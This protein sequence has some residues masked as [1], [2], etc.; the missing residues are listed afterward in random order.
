M[1]HPHLHLNLWPYNKINIS[2]CALVVT[3]PLAHKYPSASY[4]RQA[5]AYGMDSFPQAGLVQPDYSQTQGYSQQNFYR[6]FGFPTLTFVMFYILCFWITMEVNIC[7]KSDKYFQTWS[8]GG[9][10]R[11]Y[12]LQILK[13]DWPIFIHHMTTWQLELCMLCHFFTIS[14]KFVQKELTWFIRFNLVCT[15][16]AGL[17]LMKILSLSTELVQIT[18]S[19]QHRRRE[20]TTQQHQSRCTTLHPHQVDHMLDHLFLPKLS[21]DHHH[22]RTKTRGQ[23]VHGT[24]LLLLGNPKNQNL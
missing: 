11:C 12:S 5:A 24:T 19:H 6:C 17:C 13:L 20:F 14:L 3:G 22:H 1:K 18:P 23:K 15:G 2:V 21:L 7:W 9:E 4:Q 16:A 10:R 8:R